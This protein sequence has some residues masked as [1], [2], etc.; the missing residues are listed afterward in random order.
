MTAAEHRHPIPAI[1]PLP[2]GAGPRAIRA[3]LI[4]EEREEFDQAYRRALDEAADT[5]ELAVV[6][7]T[8]EHW[9][10]RAIISADP[11]EYRRMLRR[12][13]QLLSGDD[14]PEDEPLARL[15]ERLA[16]LGV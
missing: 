4:A 15:K 12:A 14:V 10:R 5:L 2:E 11:Q 7:D 9:R 6:L 13:A 3:A 8:L 16:R 1:P